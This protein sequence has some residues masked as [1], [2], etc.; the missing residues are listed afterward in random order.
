MK[1]KKE[2][3]GS[4]GSGNS[5]PSGG[6]VGQ[7]KCQ[8]N[9]SKT[10]KSC[11]PEEKKR[12]HPPGDGAMS[13]DEEPPTCGKEE[14]KVSSEEKY[15]NRHEV[16]DT[17]LRDESTN[18]LQEDESKLTLGMG[19]KRELSDDRF[20]DVDE[21]TY[22]TEAK[23]GRHEEGPKHFSRREQSSPNDCRNYNESGTPYFDRSNDQLKC[24]KS[25]K[26]QLQN[27]HTFVNANLFLERLT[28]HDMHSRLQS[29][30]NDSFFQNSNILSP[31]LNHS[32]FRHLNHHQIEAIAKQNLQDLKYRNNNVFNQEYL[33][34]SRFNAPSIRAL[35][36]PLLMQKQPKELH[37]PD[38]L[39]QDFE[40][41]F[42]DDNVGEKTIW[43]P[44]E[45]EDASLVKKPEAK[46]NLN[47]SLGFCDQSCEL[48][49]G[50]EE[51]SATVS[52]QEDIRVD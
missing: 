20:P 40:T 19:I 27:H 23:K 1:H 18:D 46:L 31:N 41:S 37:A 5:A 15:E 17:K 6:G 33:G 2:D 38:N 35:S 39:Q 29:D 25:Y 34:A 24:M 22:E 8:C 26:E 4:A 51:G 21:S 44:V 47:E 43:S 28:P 49:Q 13:C 14:V 16:R 11:S 12:E 42:D 9:A 30:A 10:G 48:S 32:M 3:G 7:S 45:Q 50:G 36:H 52:S